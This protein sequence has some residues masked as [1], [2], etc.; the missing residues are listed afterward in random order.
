MNKPT[1][2]AR[3]GIDHDDIDLNTSSNEQF[4]TVMNARLSRRNMLRGGAA[5]AATALLSTFGLTACGGS[6]D[7][8]V[9]TAPAPVGNTPRA[10]CMAHT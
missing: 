2:L 8:P 7:D 5:T 9:A 10:G 6:D 4:S 1:D 3:H